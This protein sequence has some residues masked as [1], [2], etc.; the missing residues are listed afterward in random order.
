MLLLLISGALGMEL[1]QMPWLPQ[2]LCC[3]ALGSEPQDV[4]AM[5]PEAFN[6]SAVRLVECTALSGTDFVHRVGTACSY[7]MCLWEDGALLETTPECCSLTNF[8]TPGYNTRT[9]YTTCQK[10][11]PLGL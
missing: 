8:G 2:H 11:K 1:S 9:G 5:L 3:A 7:C 6:H 10:Y 4:R